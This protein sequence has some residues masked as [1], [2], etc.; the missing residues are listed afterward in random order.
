MQ[1]VGHMVEKRLLDIILDELEGDY[2]LELKGVHWTRNSHWSE[3]ICQ[4]PDLNNFAKL[5]ND[6]AKK[7]AKGFKPNNLKSDKDRLKDNGY[8]DRRLHIT[9]T[10]NENKPENIFIDSNEVFIER[11]LTFIQN[12]CQNGGE[13]CSK[14]WNQ[15]QIGK[16]YKEAVDIRIKN[17]NKYKYVELKALDTPIDETKEG[18]ADNPLFAIIESI[19]NYYLSPN[20]DKIEELIILA[21]IDY[22]NKYLNKREVYTSIQKLLRAFKEQK[23]PISIKLQYI[24]CTSSIYLKEFK[25]EFKKFIKE[26]DFKEKKSKIDDA[27]KRKYTH[28]AN[29]K[30]DTIYSWLSGYKLENLFKVKDYEP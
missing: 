20:Q 17:N 10:R 27:T 19:K 26:D 2:E 13:I 18:K 29:Y 28:A 16:S 14:Y 12:D 1:E 5:I 25:T 11:L 21:P 24:D 9:L 3:A 30:L 22:W 6:Y 7:H 8:K 23:E 4:I 15:Y